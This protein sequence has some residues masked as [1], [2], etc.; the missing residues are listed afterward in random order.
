MNYKGDRFNGENYPDPTAYEA[1]KNVDREDRER[2]IL[3]KKVIK[4]IQNV[5]LFLLLYIQVQDICSLHRY[6]HMT[7]REESYFYSL[8]QL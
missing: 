1:I 7:I 2:D 3:A 5:A 8:T 6:R 4:T